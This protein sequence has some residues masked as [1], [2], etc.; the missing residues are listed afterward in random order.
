MDIQPLLDELC[1]DLGFCLPPA[2]QANLRQAPPVDVDQ[3]TD[4]VLVAEGLPPDG[5]KDLRS[6]VR[7]RVECCFIK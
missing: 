5:H 7:E 1:V 6:Q 3:F 4:A 2:D